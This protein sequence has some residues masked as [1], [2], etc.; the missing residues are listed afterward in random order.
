MG[1]ELQISPG[2]VY[3]KFYFHILVDCPNGSRRSRQY[4]VCANLVSELFIH[5]S[6]LTFFP[7]S[8]RFMA[9]IDEYLCHSYIISY[10]PLTLSEGLIQKKRP[11]RAIALYT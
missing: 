11:R 10:F 4:G 2:V 1:D 3:R 7:S 6:L 8:K 5:S 9:A